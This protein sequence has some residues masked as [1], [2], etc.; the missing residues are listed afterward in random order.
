MHL[1]ASRFFKFSLGRTPKPPFAQAFGALVASF[2]PPYPGSVLPPHCRGASDGPGNY[3]IL[4]WPKREVILLHYGPKLGRC[5]KQD[6]CKWPP[7]N[8]DFRIFYAVCP[9]VQ[10]IPEIPGKCICGVLDFKI[11]L[12]RTPKPLGGHPPI[13]DRLHRPWSVV[14]KI[15]HEENPLPAS[16]GRKRSVCL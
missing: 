3:C 12:G 5:Y 6:D 2:A 7:F 8:H 1:R 11:F 4:N 10:F 15:V 16:F 13:P 14:Q 9:P